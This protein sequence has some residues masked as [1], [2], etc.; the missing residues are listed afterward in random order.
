MQAVSATAIVL[1]VRLEICPEAGF[2][3]YMLVDKNRHQD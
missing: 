3:M 2:M 1:L